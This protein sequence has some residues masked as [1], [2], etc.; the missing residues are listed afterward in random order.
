MNIKIPQVCLVVLVGPSGS[1]KT[2]FAR[3]HFQPIEIL[4]SDHCRALVSDDE[5]DQSVTGDAFEVLHLIAGKRLAN[6]RLTV[7]D[8]TSVQPEARKSLIALARQ[9]HCLPVAI[10]LNLEPDLCHERNQARDDRTFEPQ[11]VRQQSEQLRRGLRRLKREGFRK[12]AVFESPEQVDL[13]TIEREPLWT[14][15][16][17][18]HGPFDIIGDVHGCFDE[19][20]LLLAKLGYQMSDDKDNPSATPPDGRKAVFV[21]NLSARGPNSPAV[22]RLVMNMVQAGNALCVPGHQEIK[23]LRKLRGKNVKATHGLA[24]TMEQLD[25]Q[26]AEFKDSVIEFIDGLISHYVLDDGNLVVAHAGMP[27]D[28]QGRASA[29]VRAF[30]MHG[31]T[32]G[33]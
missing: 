6:Q 23:L 14:D 2:T 31:E 20:A 12:I 4:S 13:V 15:R 1:G 25:A 19:L 24:E 22:L 32:T 30:A 21:G 27:Q 18:E 9:Y 3:K 7:V 10:V 29:K 28:L 16:R 5:N 8:A 17:H 26:P 33:E 11:V